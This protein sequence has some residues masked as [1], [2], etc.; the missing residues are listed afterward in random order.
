MRADPRA[1]PVRLDGGSENY[2]KAELGNVTVVSIANLPNAIS[3]KKVAQLV[4]GSLNAAKIR[5]PGAACS[6][7]RSAFWRPGS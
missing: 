3:L 7:V 1:L 2:A 5:L 4:L 6:A